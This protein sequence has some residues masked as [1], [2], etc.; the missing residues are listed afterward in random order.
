MNRQVVVIIRLVT[1]EEGIHVYHAT[2]QYGIQAS[3]LLVSAWLHDIYRAIIQD[4]GI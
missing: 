3:S 1:L 4:V 2:Q